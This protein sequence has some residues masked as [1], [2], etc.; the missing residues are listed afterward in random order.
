VGLYY[1]FVGFLPCNVADRSFLLKCI[2]SVSVLPLKRT[3][4]NCLKNNLVVNVVHILLG[5]HQTTCVLYRGQGS[6]TSPLRV[7]VTAPKTLPIHFLVRMFIALQLS[8]HVCTQ[9]RSV[10]PPP[11]RIASDIPF[12]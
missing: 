4:F 9:L 1:I 11:H 2:T 6:H 7:Q 10:I 12:G 3:D 8:S 5:L